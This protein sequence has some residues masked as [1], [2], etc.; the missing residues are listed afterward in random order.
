MLS[1]GT[2]TNQVGFV[3]VYTHTCV[4]RPQRQTIRKFIFLYVSRYDR[5]EGVDRHGGCNRKGLKKWRNIVFRY[6]SMTIV[7]YRRCYS[8]SVWSHRV[9]RISVVHDGSGYASLSVLYFLLFS[10]CLHSEETLDC[11]NFSDC[12][13]YRL[14]S[15]NL[16]CH[17]PSPL[18]R[19]L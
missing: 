14:L 13:L 19:D 2:L 16:F 4:W 9:T 11:Q 7:F 6:Y 15:P 17:P 3:V 1:K 8:K 18:V 10:S 12:G 5:T